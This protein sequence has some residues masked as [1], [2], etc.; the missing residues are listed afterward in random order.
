MQRFRADCARFDILLG[1]DPFFH[2]TAPG[3]GDCAIWGYSQWLA[4]AGVSG[5]PAMESWLV[6]T[7]GL[8]AM[9]SPDAF[10]PAS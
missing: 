4:E 7:R 2:G 5:T 6:R 3:I 1:G 9:K 10:F 8:Q